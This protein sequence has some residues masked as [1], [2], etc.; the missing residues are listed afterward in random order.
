MPLESRIGSMALNPIANIYQALVI[1]WQYQQSVTPESRFIDVGF[2]R[3]HHQI[4]WD[5]IP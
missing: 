1:I 2:L 5:A 4:E 3:F